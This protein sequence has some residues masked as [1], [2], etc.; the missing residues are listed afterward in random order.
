MAF[1]WNIMMYECEVEHKS[2][3]FCMFVFLFLMN[4]IL[5]PR[6]LAKLFGF[7][8]FFCMSPAPSLMLN[9]AAPVVKD[10]SAFLA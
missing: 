7:F 4:I 8:F 3:F 1:Y 5:P 2:F 10:L 6:T 9:L